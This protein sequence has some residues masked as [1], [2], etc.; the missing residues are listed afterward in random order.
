MLV[1]TL[2]TYVIWKYLLNTIIEIQIQLLIFHIQNTGEI[3]QK[4]QNQHD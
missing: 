3:Y 1:L 4:F 2:W